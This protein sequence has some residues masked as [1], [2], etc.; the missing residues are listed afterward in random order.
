M[1]LKNVGEHEGATVVQL[2]ISDLSASVVR[3]VKQLKAFRK[4]RLAAGEQR[5]VGFRIDE[6]DLKFFNAQLQQVAEAGAFEVQVGLDSQTVQTQ[7]FE[8][9]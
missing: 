7:R 9:R 8:L 4:I 2:Y 3:P 5:Q 1:T 6:N